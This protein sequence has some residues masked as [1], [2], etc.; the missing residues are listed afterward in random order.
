[1]D[2]EYIFEKANLLLGVSLSDWKIIQTIIDMTFERKKGEL[3]AELKISDSE[4]IRESIR[5]LF[6]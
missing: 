2:I 4:E 5:L 3:E 1:M 6:G